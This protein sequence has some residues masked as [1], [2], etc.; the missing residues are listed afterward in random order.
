MKQKLF[1]LFLLTCLTISGISAQVMIR[2]LDFEQIDVSG[3]PVSWGQLNSEEKYTMRL[4][5]K[6]AH[7]G[8][9]S[10]LIEINDTTPDRGYA[11]LTS[12]I[13]A[14]NLNTRNK[15]KINAYIKTENFKDG[16]ATIGLQL[17]D[18]DRVIKEVNSLNKN[19]SGT[20]DWTLH[21][22]E[23]PIS[24]DVKFIR[25]VFQ[26]TGYGKAWIDDFEIFMDDVALDE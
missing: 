14:N 12:G 4:D 23:L 1:L 9:C 6:V 11:M 10:F 3:H 18:E 5:N 2:N 16:I 19:P 17:N 8:Q 20:T 13:I 25:F 15:I 7:S 26:V 22:L 21:T 24:H